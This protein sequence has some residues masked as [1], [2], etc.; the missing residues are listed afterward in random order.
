RAKALGMALNGTAI[1]GVLLLPLL[2]LGAQ[3]FGLPGT[4]TTL[5]L[6]SLVV[7]LA[8]SKIIDRLGA[9][10]GDLPPANNP[11]TAKLTRRDLLRTARFRSLA[12][13]FSVAVF[14][15]VGVYSQLIN[16]LRP[17]LGFDGAALAMTGCVALAI[18]GRFAVSWYTGQTNWRKV[19]AANFL[20]QSI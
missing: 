15:Q 6:L 10:S 19:A 2:S 7:L 8:M 17:V 14:I 13:A 16:R 5:G 18:L 3:R 12:L 1:G 9:G 4:L 20:M 11:P